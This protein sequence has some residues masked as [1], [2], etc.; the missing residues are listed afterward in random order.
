MKFPRLWDVALRRIVV[1]LMLFV[2]INDGDSVDEPDISTSDYGITIAVSIHENIEVVTQT[3]DKTYMFAAEPTT[4]THAHGL[5]SS[6]DERLFES[7]DGVLSTPSLDGFYTLTDAETS[8]TLTLKTELSPTI[9]STAVLLTDQYSTITQNNELVITT[10]HTMASIS[11]TASPVLPQ[12]V[13]MLGFSL[14]TEFESIITHTH[15]DS[16]NFIENHNSGSSDTHATPT[17]MM[18]SSVVQTMSSFALDEFSSHISSQPLP[19]HIP[20]IPGPKNESN[21]ATDRLEG[22]S[23]FN[24]WTTAPINGTMS[25]TDTT[26]DESKTNQI[27]IVSLS[28]II[29]IF[30]LSA[31]ILRIGNRW[32][33]RGIA[34]EE[35]RRE[36]I[37]G[38]NQTTKKRPSITKPVTIRMPSILNIKTTGNQSVRRSKPITQKENEGKSPANNKPKRNRTLEA[39][40]EIGALPKEA[41]YRN[42][43]KAKATPPRI[44]TIERELLSNVCV[45][46]CANAFDNLALDFDSQEEIHFRGH[47]V[48]MR[49]EFRIDKESVDIRQTFCATDT[50]SDD[51]ESSVPSCTELT[52]ETSE[53]ESG[54]DSKGNRRDKR[55]KIVKFDRRLSNDSGF[56][57]NIRLQDIRSPCVNSETIE[58]ELTSMMTESDIVQSYSD[59]SQSDKLNFLKTSCMRERA[60]RRGSK[61]RRSPNSPIVRPSE[62]SDADQSSS[63]TGGNETPSDDQN[64]KTPLTSSISDTFK[65]ENDQNYSVAHRSYSS[66][67]QRPKP[68]DHWECCQKA[69]DATTQTTYAPV[70]LSPMRWVYE[71]DV[72]V[73]RPRSEFELDFLGP[74]YL[75]ECL[76]N[77]DNDDCIAF[78]R[79]TENIDL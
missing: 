47:F 52:L 68:Q 5:L 15:T 23:D 60:P 53:T 64:S 37:K 22:S 77:F 55:R 54:S 50:L 79:K 27:L 21:L 18:M 63:E 14:T 34:I 40:I 2:L 28:V 32:K 43:D 10:M 59:D 3:T 1:L 9:V 19:S 17:Q 31:L 48:P 11:A 72:L 70:T 46:K 7:T 78:Q 20:R 26:Q 58:E 25:D 39:L 42:T 8:G 24:E 61:R 35:R 76:P 51:K 71:D 4:L 30:G 65:Y 38:S 74:I 56:L 73:L 6:D 29:G 62:V 57:E 44:T 36:R 66:C 67:N 12:V 69:R 33:K 49:C 45:G 75:A 13:S 41:A 16:Q